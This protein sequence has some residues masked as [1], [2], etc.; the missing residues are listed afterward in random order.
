MHVQDLRYPYPTAHLLLRVRIRVR[1]GLRIGDGIWVRVGVRAGVAVR[2]RVGVRLR[3][4]VIACPMRAARSGLSQDLSFHRTSARSK[5][6]TIVAH[7]TWLGVGL[8][9]G[10]GLGVGVG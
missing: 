1:I 9:V 4:R 8:E 3:V 10:L 5:A 6:P 7:S 2:V